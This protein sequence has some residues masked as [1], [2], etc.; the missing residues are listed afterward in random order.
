MSKYI[1]LIFLFLSACNLAQDYER[2][3]LSLNDQFIRSEIEANKVNLEWWTNFSDPQLVNLIKEALEDNKDIL[4]SL[5]QI[6]QARAILGITRSNQYPQLNAGLDLNRQGFSEHLNSVSV[7]NQFGIFGD[8]SFE[9]D[10]WGKLRNAT[11]AR[12]REML[13]TELNYHSL[14]LTLI[15]D[16]ANI[17]FEL[18]S[19]TQQLKIAEKTIKNRHQSTT[20]LTERFKKGVVP[21]LDVEQARIEE[22]DAEARFYELTRQRQNL[23]HA[24]FVLLG[25]TPE[26]TKFVYS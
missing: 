21:E 8:L 23:E 19:L 2:P 7:Q 4:I 10:L 15:S 24:L 18:I 6:E 5:A 20:I 3:A 13:A 1:S 16:V 11:D 9:V 17:Y 12:K 14:R 26:Y 25:K 22:L